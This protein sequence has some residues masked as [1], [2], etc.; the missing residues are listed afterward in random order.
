V[1][2]SCEHGIEPSI[3]IKGR[4]LKFLGWLGKLQKPFRVMHVVCACVLPC[5]F[6]M[7]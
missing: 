7:N 5:N 3:Y 2:D 1:T 6:R 4:E